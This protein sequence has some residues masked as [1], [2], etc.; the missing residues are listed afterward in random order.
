VRRRIVAKKEWLL[1]QIDKMTA[2]VIEVD[3]FVK[4][5]EALEYI[6]NNFQAVKDDIDL[7]DKLHNICK[8]HGIKISNEDKKLINEIYGI[9]SNLSQSIMDANDSIDRKK[10]DIKNK[11]TKKQIPEFEKEVQVLNKELDDP[12]F[13]DIES[14]PDSIIEELKK[15]DVSKISARCEQF[16]QWQLTLD[17]EVDQFVEVDLVIRKI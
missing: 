3:Q 10:D 12:K 11:I 1:E 13:L 15:F 16:K 14:N 5:V 8:E 2:R 7:Y 6:D 9:I 17:M 4:Q